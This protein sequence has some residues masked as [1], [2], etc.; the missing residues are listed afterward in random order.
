MSQRRRPMAAPPSEIRSASRGRHR[1]LVVALGTLGAFVL[2]GA[3]ALGGAGRSPGS[4]SGSGVGAAAA[5]FAAEAPVGSASAVPDP[6]HE[7]YGFV[8]YWEMDRTI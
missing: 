3:L 8:P 6:G 1:R 4:P 5:S 2:I 7:V